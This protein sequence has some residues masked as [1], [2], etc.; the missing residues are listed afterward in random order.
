MVDRNKGRMKIRRYVKLVLVKEFFRMFVEIKCLV[1]FMCI[2]RV[3]KE[4]I[5]CAHQ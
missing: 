2:R 5:V 1:Y 3:L 4:C